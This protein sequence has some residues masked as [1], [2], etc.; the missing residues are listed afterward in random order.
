MSS[1]EGYV[2]PGT[3]SIT[4]QVT[5]QK[6]GTAGVAAACAMPHS[7]SRQKEWL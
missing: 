1:V 7:G 3:I 4:G 6:P 2:S 5:P